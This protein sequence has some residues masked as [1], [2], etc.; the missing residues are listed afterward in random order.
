MPWSLRVAAEA[1]SE[2]SALR[3]L[4]ASVPFSRLLKLNRP[5]LPWAIAGC[6]ASG[7]LGAQMPAFAISMSSIVTVYYVPVLLLPADLRAA[8]CRGFQGRRGAAAN[9]AVVTRHEF[10]VGSPADLE[11]LPAPADGMCFAVTPMQ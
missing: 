9:S 5:E 11:R 10:A 1:L 8:G 6:I 2:L 7:L 4:Q 3:G